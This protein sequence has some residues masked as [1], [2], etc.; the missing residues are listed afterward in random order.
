MSIDPSEASHEISLV[1]DELARLI[2]TNVAPEELDVFTETASEYHANPGAVRDRER[3][4]ELGFGV[5][6]AMVT[7]VAL[8]VA[9]AVVKYLLSAFAEATVA[10]SSRAAVHK[11]ADAGFRAQHRVRADDAAVRADTRRRPGGA[12]ALAAAQT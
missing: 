9:T 4:E 7:P 10:E 3:D 6:L 2:V 5:D 8:A 11:I 12:P 1:A